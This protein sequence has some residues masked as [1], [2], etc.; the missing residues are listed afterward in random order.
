M[1]VLLGTGCRPPTR[2]R[3]PPG[4]GRRV[5][6]RRKHTR[7]IAL[8]M[9]LR[10]PAGSSQG[11]PGKSIFARTPR[12][13]PG[14]PRARS[15]KP[16]PGSSGTPRLRGRR[17]VWLAPTGTSAVPSHLLEGR[18]CARPR[19]RAWTSTPAATARRPHRG[20]Y[21]GPMGRDNWPTLQ[22]RYHS[23]APTNPRTNPA[24][25]T[26]EAGKPA[27]GEAIHRARHP[28]DHPSPGR[29][30]THCRWRIVVAHREQ[31]PTRL[32]R[33][34]ITWPSLFR[35]PRHS[36]TRGAR[37]CDVVVRGARVRRGRASVFVDR[38]LRARSPRV[39][40]G[41]IDDVLALE[42]NKNNG[43]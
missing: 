39:A 20:C 41:P 38:T 27:H 21:R 28:G 2:R 16:A 3:H 43:R 7:W 19:P 26:G 11:T 25:V 37:R 14:A 5:W 18:G 30:L 34:D 33:H 8:K 6:G 9:A 15:P 42:R 13:A 17:L 4:G 10:T 23:S 35:V 32:F 1:R 31:S 36:S 40:G 24:T 29:A 22:G 12:E